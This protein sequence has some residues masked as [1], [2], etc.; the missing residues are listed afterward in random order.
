[1]KY[2]KIIKET[3]DGILPQLGRMYSDQG[4][5]VVSQISCEPEFVE[6][7]KA[8]AFIMSEDHIKDEMR[9]S[10]VRYKRRL[11]EFETSLV[12]VKRRRDELAERVL[13]ED[14]LAVIEDK[15]YKIA[16]E[17]STS[18]LDRDMESYKN[19]YTEIFP[20]TR[21]DL[22]HLGVYK[23]ED[24]LISGHKGMAED[25][26]IYCVEQDTGCNCR[27]VTCTKPRKTCECVHFTTDANLLKALNDFCKHRN[28]QFMQKYFDAIVEVVKRNKTALKKA[29]KSC[30][31]TNIMCIICFRSMKTPGRTCKSC[32]T[33][34]N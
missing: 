3:M 10:P 27:C 23:T 20:P 26:C 28:E 30:P 29:L 14:N 8:Q 13:T 4:V 18:S 9:K 25:I 32:K 7:A 33:C 15:L 5:E 16:E 19:S 2:L 6:L 17:D 22:L 34:K 12:L 31:E 24:F 1:M 21:S 11:S